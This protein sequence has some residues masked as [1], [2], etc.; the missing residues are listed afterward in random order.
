[1]QA[2]V[3]KSGDGG[4]TWA[5]LSTLEVPSQ[6]TWIATGPPGSIVLPSGAILIPADSEV[7]GGGSAASHSFVR[8]GHVPEAGSYPL[9]ACATPL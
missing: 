3:L 6:W 8:C 2:G 7:G 1:M 4:A 9:Q 5:L